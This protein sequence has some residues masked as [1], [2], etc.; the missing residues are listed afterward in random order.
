[1][2][3]NNKA[4]KGLISCALIGILIFLG[5]LCA[6]SA[7]PKPGRGHG[8][9]TPTPSPTVPP[10]PAPS[11]TATPTPLPPPPTLT[12]AWDPPNDPSVSSYTLWTGF[13][14]GGE[15]QQTPLPNVTTTTVTLTSGTTYFFY[16]TAVNSNGQS[17][18]SNE[19]TYTTP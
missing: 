1:M 11:P 6:P 13:T 19:V 2:S 17:L 5:S 18:P 15:N 4:L 3:N 9:P 7:K 8:K 10:T 16:V 14:S 12:L